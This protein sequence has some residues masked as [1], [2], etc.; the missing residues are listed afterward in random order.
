MFS[1]DGN[2]YASGIDLIR[3]LATKYEDKDKVANDFD[4]NF[5]EEFLAYT[6]LVEEYRKL[7]LLT[8]EKK[9]FTTK[10]QTYEFKMQVLDIA[11]LDK[12]PGF[13]KR[14]H[15]IEQSIA[16]KDLKKSLEHDSKISRVKSLMKKY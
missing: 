1:I 11:N 6:D 16:K 5:I 4:C 10:E 7:G 12:Y 8:T 13:E 2:S 9:I 14:F 15:S 3:N